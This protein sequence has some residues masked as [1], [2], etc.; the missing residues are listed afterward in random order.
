[1]ACSPV[2]KAVFFAHTE[3]KGKQA[4]DALPCAQGMGYKGDV[5]SDREAVFLVL[6]QLHQQCL[7]HHSRKLK[8]IIE[9][10]ECEWAKNMRELFHEMITAS[11]EWPGW[12][13]DGVYTGGPDAEQ[14]KDWE[15]RYDDILKAG[16]DYYCKNPPSRHYL[17]G[18]NTRAQLAADK[19]Q[20]LLFI[21]N[22]WIPATNNMAERCLRAHKRELHQS[23]TFRSS[24]SIDHRC[25]VASIVQTARLRDM[26][27]YQLLAE[28]LSR[29]PEQKEPE[30]SDQS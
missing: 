12:S 4:A 24:E 18:H 7:A 11:H 13:G 8:S 23:T 3:K 27:I 21:H 14:V 15:A 29:S 22:P 10:E 25:N 6:G 26:Q 28:I 19:D 2:S 30:T 20:V 5:I 9:I 16:R 17:D 1:M